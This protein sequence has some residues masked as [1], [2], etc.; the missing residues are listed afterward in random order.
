MVSCPTWSK[1]LGRTLWRWGQRTFKVEIWDFNLGNFYST[2]KRLLLTSKVWG[3]PLYDKRGSKVLIYLSLL[4]FLLPCL[5]IA[6][7]E[8]RQVNQN[9]LVRKYLFAL[10]KGRKPFLLFLSSRIIS[11]NSIEFVFVLRSFEENESDE[12]PWH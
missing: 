8:Q 12:M 7:H 9:F 5:L 10:L 2:P 3:K 6:V 4:L 1:N 11:Q